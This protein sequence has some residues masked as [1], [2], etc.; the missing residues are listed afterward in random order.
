MIFE[1]ARN[2]LKADII[3][4]GETITILD[5]GAWVTS[6][7]FTKDS[8]EP[9]KDY[10]CK[11]TYGDKQY[12]LTINKTRRD[13]LIAAYGKDSKG[14]INKSCKVEA[15]NC[16]VGNKM[17]KTIVLF[18]IDGAKKEASLGYEA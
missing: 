17:L 3:K 5:E 18:P 9:K 12:D 10:V 2:W 7:K 15:V 1:E 13:T 11:V 8:G 6:A 4:A 14:W 16:M